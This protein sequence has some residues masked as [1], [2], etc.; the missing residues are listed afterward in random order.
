MKVYFDNGSKTP[1]RSRAKADERR[2]II[3]LSVACA[4]LFITCLVLFARVGSLSRENSDLKKRLS[5]VAT[6]SVASKSDAKKMREEN[7]NA[8]EG[9]KQSDESDNSEQSTEDSKPE[10]QTT[11]SRQVLNPSEAGSQAASKKSSGSDLKGLAGIG[12]GISKSTNGSTKS[13]AGQ[14]LGKLPNIASKSGDIRQGG[15]KQDS[16]G[17]SGTASGGLSKSGTSSAKTETKKTDT[18]N[19]TSEAAVKTEAAPS[20]N[21]GQN[22][23]DY[24]PPFYV[25]PNKQ[26]EN[27]TSIA[28]GTVLTDTNVDYNNPGKYFMS[29]DIEHGGYVYKRI[30]GKSFQE[31]T[32]IPLSSLKYIKVIHYNFEGKV[33]VGEMIVNKDIVEDVLNIFKELFD[34]KYQINSMH[35]VDDYWTGNPMSSDWQS[36]DVNNTSAF[37]YRRKVGSKNLSLHAYGRAIDLNPQQN[38]YV[39]YSS[40]GP[41]WSHSN[42]DAYV[43]RSSGQPHMINHDDKAYQ[44]FTKYGFKWGGDFNEPKD[45]QHFEKE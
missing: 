9:T 7:S 5:D 17:L 22:N 4:I 20:Q 15:Q 31:N 18:S 8:E 39:S 10:D 34:A 3:I 35:L 42:A 2:T 6:D 32:E 12:A 44:I 21:T 19:K 29:M 14:D 43:E 40:G 41:R 33:Q 13:A 23:D 11:K 25:D 26:L 38:P 28:A 30:A 45:Y 27:L 1:G 16:A 36:I 37:C 24:D